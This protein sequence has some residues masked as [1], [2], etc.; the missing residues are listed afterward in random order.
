MYWLV[1]C[2]LGLQEQVSVAGALLTM[3][4][5]NIACMVPQAPGFVGSVQ[6]AT[7]QAL[8]IFGV[9]RDMAA[10]YSVLVHAA[11]FF[12]ITLAG[13]ICLLRNQFT[14][15]EISHSAESI[16][17]GIGGADGKESA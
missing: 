13:V 16:A 14:F 15:G 8:A 11:F 7:I 1:L 2:G 4:A 5:V 3:V 6:F 9:D 10:A 17:P 12:P